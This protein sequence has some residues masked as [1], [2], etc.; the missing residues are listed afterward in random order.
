MSMTWSLDPEL[1]RV[2]DF[3][4]RYYSLLFAGTF[5]IGHILVQKMFK[6][7]GN[8]PMEVDRL[9]VYAIVGTLAG[10]RLAHCLFYEPEY[11]LRHPLEILK[12]W[13]GG[14][15]SHGGFAGMAIGLVLAWRKYVKR[16]S[17]LQVLDRC[18]VPSLL[19]ASLIRFGNLFNSEIVGRATD[20]PFA[21]VFTRIDMIPRHPAQMYESI[22]YLALFFGAWWLWKN[23]KLR[24]RHGFFLGLASASSTVVRFLVEFVKEDQA[25]FE[26]GM[27]LNMGQLLSIPFFVGGVA[28]MLGLHEKLLPAK[29]PYA[30]GEAPDASDTKKSRRKQRKKAAA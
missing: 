9:L 11:Y 14:L 20:G 1:I 13:T 22:G 12:I 26:A 29:T 8:D 17:L 21:T 7:E 3:A 27:A 30:A 24:E 28:L 15:A 25:A 16:L 5:V 19:S 18:F 2:G 23:T 4:L 6:E 10:A